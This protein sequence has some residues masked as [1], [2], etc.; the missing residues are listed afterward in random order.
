ML[1]YSVIPRNLPAANDVEISSTYS[2]NNYIYIF[3][4]FRLLFLILR[5]SLSD[6][7]L[8]GAFARENMKIA[9]GWRIKKSSSLK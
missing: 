3:C 7:H 6:I 2:A 4:R 5:V 1:F 9:G 8:V